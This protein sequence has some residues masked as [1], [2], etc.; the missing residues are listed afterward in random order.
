V[1][2]TLLIML[3]VVVGT[4]IKAVAGP[5]PPSQCVDNCPPDL[6]PPLPNG[7]P[8]TSS[9]YGFSFDYPAPWNVKT[10]TSHIFDA[11]LAS[12]GQFEIDAG[13]GQVDLAQLI[14][15]Q[16]ASFTEL[17]QTS[18]GSNIRGAEIGFQP[19]QGTFY[20]GTAN[21]NA[22]N[23][24]D[25]EVAIIVVTRADRWVMAT[26]ISVLANDSTCDADEG[27][28]G[29]GAIRSFFPSAHNLCPVDFGDFEVPL[30]YWHWSS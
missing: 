8:F 2:T 26:G 27:Y 30:T 5:N 10:D 13:T 12:G 7:G 20:A 18:R 9:Q 15:R 25:V 14:Q 19:G 11:S 16:L 4:A 23:V 17:V 21:D 6:G 24:V 29:L 1:K 3:V 22:G 28:A